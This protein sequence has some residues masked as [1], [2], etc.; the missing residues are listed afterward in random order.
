MEPKVFAI[1]PASGSSLG[2]MWGIIV[3]LALMLV[4]TVAVMGWSLYAARH[5]TFSLSPESLR[6][7]ADIY[8]RTIRTSAL[9]VEG[10]RRVDF[11]VS[12]EFLPKWRTNG[13]G[14]PGYQAGWFKLRNGEKALLFLADRQRAV[15]VPTREGYALLISPQD[16]DGFLAALKGR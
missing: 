8:G 3:L 10:A 9:V 15:Y 13:I 6:I 7:S 16:P 1:A 5:A 14:L 11:G 2:W 12:P 4:G